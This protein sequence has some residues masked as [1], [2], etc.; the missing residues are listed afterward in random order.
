MLA[1][2]KLL[3]IVDRRR[4]RLRNFCST[5][6]LKPLRRTARLDTA[7]AGFGLTPC[8]DFLR[9]AIYVANAHASFE[10][11]RH[12]TIAALRPRAG[13]GAYADQRRD[14]ADHMVGFA[15]RQLF[16]ALAAQYSFV[17]V[18]V[19][20]LSCQ[21][22]WKLAQRVAVVGSGVGTRGTDRQSVDAAGNVV[23]FR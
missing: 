7:R 3:M 1:A 2:T 14:T 16:C 12:I 19:L 21:P 5:L 17:I 23:N 22:P 11:T 6:T 15:R 9:G 4:P 13:D 10:L 18:H 20:F 8:F